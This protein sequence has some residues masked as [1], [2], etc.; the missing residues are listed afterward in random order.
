[1]TLTGPKIA[2]AQETLKV[3]KN[4]FGFI[5]VVS[6][7]FLTEVRMHLGMCLDIR[8]TCIKFMQTSVF[9]YFSDGPQ[10]LDLADETLH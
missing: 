6:V 1:M 8:K 2:S 3:F 4:S 10:L 7:R 5:P 9:V